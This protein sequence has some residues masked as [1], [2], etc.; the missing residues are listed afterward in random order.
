MA[1]T[2]VVLCDTNI[3][4]ELSKENNDVLGE[5]K[6]IGQDNI[7]VS[8]ITAVEFMYG[9]LNK[10]ELTEIKKALNAIHIIHL[11]RTISEKALELID[12]YSLSHNLAVP[13]ALIAATSLIYK[14]PVY[15]EL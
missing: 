14:L 5:L 15:I 4:I 8:S 1:A 11:D 6:A 9:A 3:L 10:K 12:Y 2:Q 13:D 7:A